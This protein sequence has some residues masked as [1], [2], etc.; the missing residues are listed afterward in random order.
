MERPPHFAAPLTT[1]LEGPY[2][3]VFGWSDGWFEHDGTFGSVRYLGAT[4]GDVSI[5]TDQWGTCRANE[6]TT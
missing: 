1:Y 3:S 6:E 4:C 5:G 2:T